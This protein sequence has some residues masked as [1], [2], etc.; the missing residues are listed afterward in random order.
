MPTRTTHE[1]RRTKEKVVTKE[2]RIDGRS[3]K[4]SKDMRSNSNITKEKRR[5]EEKESCSETKPVHRIEN[6]RIDVRSRISRT[7]ERRRACPGNRATHTNQG[8][9]HIVSAS[10]RIRGQGTKHRHLKWRA[11]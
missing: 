9:Y 2:M 4:G 6:E 10:R 3:I 1:H 7:A 5:P 8:H 11:T